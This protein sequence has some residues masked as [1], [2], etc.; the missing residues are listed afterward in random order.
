MVRYWTSDE[1]AELKRLYGIGVPR[2][3][4]AEILDRSPAAIDGRRQALG[5]HARPTARAW[6]RAEDALVRAADELAL[7]VAEVAR[8]LGRPPG[9]VRWRRHVLELD[10]RRRRA[11]T[12][13][14]DEAIR[15][16]WRDGGDLVQ[17]S[18]ALGRSQ[19]ALRLRADQL[20]VFDPVRRRRWLPDEDAQLRAGYERGAT[21]ALIAARLGRSTGAVA[22]RARKL[23]LANYARRWSPGEEARLA[24]L[25]A[26]GVPFEQA[27][28]ALARTPG[29]L[30]IRA[31]RLGI[32]A[33]RDGEPAR[34]RRWTPAEDA[35][36]ARRAGLGPARLALMLGRSSAAVQRR[37]AVL[38]LQQDR[39]RSPHN[40]VGEWQ[41]HLTPAQRRLLAREFQ[42]GRGRLLLSLASRLRLS[43][44]AVKQLAAALQAT[45]RQQRRE[46]QR[47]S[48]ARQ[49]DEDEAVG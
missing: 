10:R 34:W 27:A 39:R 42:P 19:G 49:P 9:A 28:G 47:A 40:P 26:Q 15:R 35:L 44:G 24:A 23:G 46:P 16:V 3:R 20:G 37:L 33:P 32:Q 12:A 29:A 48:W 1:D 21:C 22:A 43:P 5:V 11:Y 4:I 14:D 2:Q 18:R 6:S 36:L 25:V 13:A 38:G 30:H 7:P 31:Q 41:R 8:R 45:P 17:L